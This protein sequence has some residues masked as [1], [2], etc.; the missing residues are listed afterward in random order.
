MPGRVP[1]QHR[2]PRAQRLAVTVQHRMRRENSRLRLREEPQVAVHLFGHIDKPIDRPQEIAGQPFVERPFFMW[3]HIVQQGDRT[4]A[5]SPCDA[6]DRTESGSHHR[7]PVA[8]DHRIGLCAAEPPPCANPRQRINAAYL[9]RDI[10]S[11][12][13]GIAAELGRSGKQQ[14]RILCRKGKNTAGNAHLGK[15]AGQSLING[16]QPPPERIG[17]AEYDNGFQCVFFLRLHFGQLRLDR[18]GMVQFKS[19]VSVRC[20]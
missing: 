7:N 8:D 10:D 2:L 17:R 20:V 13:S 19:T 4:H 5:A 3:D 1:G 11:F 12:G 14:R 18:L 15:C 16:R 6:A 9:P